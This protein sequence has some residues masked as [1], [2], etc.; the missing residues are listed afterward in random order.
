MSEKK[1]NIKKLR[2]RKRML[3]LRKEIRENRN[4]SLVSN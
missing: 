4:N 1:R 3:E 2:F